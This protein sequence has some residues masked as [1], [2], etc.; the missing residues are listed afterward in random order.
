MYDI[1]DFSLD[2]FI[3]AHLGISKFDSE[4]LNVQC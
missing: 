4:D 2:I 3:Q 1:Y